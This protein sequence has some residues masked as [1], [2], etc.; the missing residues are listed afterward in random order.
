MIT[1]M[2]KFVEL[3]SDCIIEYKFKEKMLEADKVDW[4]DEKTNIANGNHLVD[5]LYFLFPENDNQGYPTGKFIKGYLNKDD[6]KQLSE[7]ITCMEANNV[8][9][10]PGDDLP[11]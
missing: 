3:S 4:V 9:G 8:T 5:G 10:I 6:I 11:F 7:I 2:K 1:I